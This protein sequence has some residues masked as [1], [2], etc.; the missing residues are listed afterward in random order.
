MTTVHGDL[1]QAE[2]RTLGLRPGDVLDFSSNV[3][4]LG[5]SPRVREAAAAAGLESYPDRDCLALREALAGRLG[6]TVESLLVGNGSTELIHLLARSRLQP[7][8]RCLVFA[9]TFGEYEAAAVATGAEVHRVE[10]AAQDDFRWR[11]DEAV[12]T[13]AELRPDLV[14]LCNPNNPTGVALEPEAVEQLG[15]AV[16]PEGLLVLDDAYMPFADTPWDPSPLL[17]RGNVA[18]LRSMAKAHALAGA[19]VGYLVARPAVIENARRLQHPWSVNAIAQAAGLA[20]LGDDDHVAAAR[21][22]IREGKVSLRSGLEGLGLAVLPSEANFLLVRVRDA[23]RVRGAL[24]RRGMAVRDCS[25]FGLPGN[26]RI[27]VRRPEECERLVEALREVLA[28]G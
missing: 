24:L 18:I 7:D 4:P 26:L 5:T 27:A 1:R 13:T 23:A 25:S 20:A 8:R 10:A 17:G 6:V 11:L 3:N 9:P 22:V 15:E 12:R 14:F 28:G 16:G 21:A 19:R 2:L